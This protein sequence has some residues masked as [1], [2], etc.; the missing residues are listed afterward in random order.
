MSRYRRSLALGGTFFFTVN[1][2]DREGRLLVDEIEDL[3]QAF[4]LARQRY[5]FKIVR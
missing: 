5:P 4:K 1:L 3:R 2:A